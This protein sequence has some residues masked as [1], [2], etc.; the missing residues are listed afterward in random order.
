[1]CWKGRASSKLDAI[2][3]SLRMGEVDDTLEPQTSYCGQVLA[4]SMPLLSLV[5]F[6]WVLHCDVARN[7][8]FG[9]QLQELFEGRTR[10]GSTGFLA[11]LLKPFGAVINLTC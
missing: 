7:T 2:Y 1:M 8:K 4:R 10:V 11:Q 9:L 5:D 3:F 6:G